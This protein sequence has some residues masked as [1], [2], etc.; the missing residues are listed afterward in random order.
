MPDSDFSEIVVLGDD[1]AAFIMG[2]H[3]EIVIRRAGATLSHTDNVE[4]LIFQHV[5]DDSRTALIDEKF[6]SYSAANIVSWL[7]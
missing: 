1:N 3:N 6:Q 2:L 5:G 7:R 4:T